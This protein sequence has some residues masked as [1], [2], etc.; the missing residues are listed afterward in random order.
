[1]HNRRTVQDLVPPRN[2]SNS[3]ADSHPLHLDTRLMTLPEAWDLPEGMAR[4]QH[5]ET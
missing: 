4:Q 2:P 5:L 3:L 1:M